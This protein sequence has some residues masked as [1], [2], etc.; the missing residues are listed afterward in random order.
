MNMHEAIQSVADNGACAS[1]AGSAFET[2]SKKLQKGPPGRRKSISKQRNRISKKFEEWNEHNVLPKTKA[3]LFQTLRESGVK[4]DALM[5]TAWDQIKAAAG[6]MQK[7][8]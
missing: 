3:E 4:D 7:G 6:K 2:A 5:Q 8:S 1:A